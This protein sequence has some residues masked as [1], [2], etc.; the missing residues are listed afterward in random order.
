MWGKEIRMQLLTQKQ[1]DEIERLKE[2]DNYLKDKS[3][4]QIIR[5]AVNLWIDLKNEIY[6]LT[7]DE[8]LNQEGDNNE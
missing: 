1:I 4:K 7:V 2:K 8:I 3:Y 6:P 5:I